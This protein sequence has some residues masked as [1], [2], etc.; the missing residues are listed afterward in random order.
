MNMRGEIIYT[1]MWP[2][3]ENGNIAKRIDPVKRKG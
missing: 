3:A 1:T 2:K